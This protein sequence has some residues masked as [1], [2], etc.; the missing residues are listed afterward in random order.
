MIVSTTIKSKKDSRNWIDQTS[1]KTLKT[2]IRALLQAI[3]VVIE[4]CYKRVQTLEESW[5]Q[6]IK[7]KKELDEIPSKSP[8]PDL[9]VYF[10]TDCSICVCKCHKCYLLLLITI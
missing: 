6:S 7:R 10:Y 3:E 4:Q 9:K 2:Q 8:S 1:V 5:Q